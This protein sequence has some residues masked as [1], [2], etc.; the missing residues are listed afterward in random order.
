MARVYAT[1][2]PAEVYRRSL[3]RPER[4][5]TIHF[6]N[7]TKEGFVVRRKRVIWRTVNGRIGDVRRN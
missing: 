7:N 1:K 6:R 5:E 4:L 3:P 2:E